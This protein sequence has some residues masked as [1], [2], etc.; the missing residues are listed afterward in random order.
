MR[1]TT[2]ACDPHSP[3]PPRPGPT[4][5]QRDIIAFLGSP[6]A[7]GSTTGAV[8]RIDTHCS[9]VFLVDE[10]AFKLKRALQY[11]YLNYSTVERR[12]EC[13]L[14]EVRLN[15]RT[16]PS[17]YHRVRAVTCDANGSLALDG[18]GPAVEWLVEMSRFDESDVLDGM[19]ERGT[20]DLA[21]MPELAR[22][23]AR[24]HAIAEWRFDHGGRRGMAWVIDG[25][26]DGFHDYGPGVLDPAACLRLTTRSHEALSHQADRLM[27]RRAEGFVRRCHGDLHLRNV[28]LL[29][30]R[31][32]LFD[33]IE[34]SDQ[35][36]CIDVLYDLAFLVMD[37]LHRGL[38]QHAHAVCNEYVTATADLDGLALMP[39][40]L[41][42]RA[43]V[44]A[45]TSATAAR[46]QSTPTA[47]AMQ[48]QAAQD[49][50]TLALSLIDPAPA[51]LVAIGG[52][53]GVGKSVVAK[54]LAPTI[55]AAP[56]ALV[57]RSD[58]IR[59]S[60]LAVGPAD[61]LGSEGYTAGVTRSV[62]R[63]LAVRATTAA[64]AGHSVIVDAVF[65]DPSDRVVIA[66]VART[67]GVP[68]TG[69]WLDAPVDTRADR[70]VRRSGDVSDAT[71][72]VL[73]EQL[74][75]DIG[76]LDWA[77]VDAAGERDAT[78]RAVEACVGITAT[79]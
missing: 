30:G 44:R 72:A 64:A 68:F 3:R 26:A 53:S 75:R 46:L 38:G 12:R 50:L 27:T 4:V 79:P 55:G 28:C 1:S 9:V 29:E 32:T 69:V 48:R 62:Y 77:R 13:C 25:N 76:N 7:Y 14:A 66:D 15:R 23:V 21:L 59:K 67:T 43:A 52:L 17:V 6:A 8:E 36:V 2:T 33:C 20:L 57:L 5:N 22:A 61:R 58:V 16:A 35:I 63:E 70:I 54:R 73:R 56:G 34:F 19:A 39:L 40:F 60:L 49:Y 10:R 11:D 74:A 71:P 42:V 37:L 65:A 18:D 47:Q 31:P 51:R 24:L 41:S 45:K 78:A